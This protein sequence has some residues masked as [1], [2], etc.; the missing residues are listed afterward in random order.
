MSFH[1]KEAQDV[2]VGAGRD[3]GDTLL[4]TM[5]VVVAKLYLTLLGPQGL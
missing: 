2:N 1:I 5:V 4:C 3:G